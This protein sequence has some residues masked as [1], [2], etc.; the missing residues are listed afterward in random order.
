MR[1][2][3]CEVMS[4]IIG[5]DFGGQVIPTYSTHPHDKTLFQLYEYHNLN[6]QKDNSEFFSPHEYDSELLV[7]SLS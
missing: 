6:C 5:R 7:N 2:F 4:E 3:S 1:V